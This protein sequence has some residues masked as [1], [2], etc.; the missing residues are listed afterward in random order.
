MYLNPRGR[1]A[2]N[3]VVVFLS[4]TSI[5]CYE[6]ENV[7]IVTNHP[8]CSQIGHKLLKRGATVPETFIAVSSCEGLVNPQDAGLGGGFQVVMYNASCNGQKAVYINARE[9]SPSVWPFPRDRTD[10]HN[11]IG[12]PGVLKGYEYLYTSKNCNYKPKL[13]WKELFQDVI[14]LGHNGF[15]L[16]NTFLNVYNQINEPFIFDIRG[17]MMYN[18]ILANTFKQIARDGPSSS[19]YNKN[20]YLFNLLMKTDFLRGALNDLL[21]YNVSVLPPTT[22]NIKF[23]KK[24]K[25]YTSNLPGSGACICAGVKILSKLYYNMKNVTTSEQYRLLLQQEVLKYMYSIQPHLKALKTK[26]LYSQITTVA[27]EIVKTMKTT[28]ELIP[29]IKPV[30]YGKIKLNNFT[31]DAPYGTTNVVIQKGGVT[32]VGTSTINWSFGSKHYIK[33][34]GFFLNNQL[35]DFS[36]GIGGHPNSPSPNA[37]PQSSISPTIIL[38]QNN[39]IELAVGGAGGGKII[40]AVF[41]AIVRKIF[42][43]QTLESSIN[44][45]RCLPMFKP[46]ETHS[47]LACEPGA[48][49]LVQ[50]LTG[51]FYSLENGYSAVTGIDKISAIF[52][53]R[54]GGEG[55]TTTYPSINHKR[56]RSRRADDNTL[57]NVDDNFNVDSIDVSEDYNDGD[58]DAETTTKKP[59]ELKVNGII[60]ITS[61]DIVR[62]FGISLRKNHCVEDYKWKECRANTICLLVHKKL[63]LIKLFNLKFW[64]D[65]CMFRILNYNDLKNLKIELTDKAD[66]KYTLIRKIMHDYIV[67]DKVD[68]TQSNTEHLYGK[69]LNAY[70]CIDKLPIELCRE[71]GICSKM[72]EI[73]SKAQLVK[74]TYDKELCRINFDNFKVPSEMVTEFV[75]GKKNYIVI[76][77]LAHMF[78]QNN[79]LNMQN[80]LWN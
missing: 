61:S 75:N 41:Q 52:D 1:Y 49:N 22:C 63:K 60:D 50:N 77:S 28:R 2:L 42:E 30:T 29:T 23:P 70:Y 16:S 68:I 33:N 78:M 46:H 25:I 62:K 38:N 21:H 56:N 59:E 15:K 39:E 37:Y 55:I 79:L 76:R 27:K 9:K 45:P 80:N 6:N 20:G 18:N 35:Y 3:A 10:F 34:L 69:R 32:L 44:E 48:R 31:L 47:V 17:D 66:N 72:M 12:I 71:I 73:M 4:I 67:N 7:K 24:L 36:Y 5:Q 53:R 65:R 54:R 51:V 11:G 43:N 58:E 14:Q 40:G 26:T 19:L 64:Y 74:F 57:D 8:K 13:E